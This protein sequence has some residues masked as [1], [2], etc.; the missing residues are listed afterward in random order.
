MGCE[1]GCK[2]NRADK[3]LEREIVVFGL[4]PELN[5]LNYLQKSSIALVIL[6]SPAYSV[7]LLA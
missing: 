6:S 4:K 1:N 3:V 7:H 2:V 5:Q